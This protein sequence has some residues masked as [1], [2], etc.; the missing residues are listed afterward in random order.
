[1][2][3]VAAD[4]LTAACYSAIQDRDC[5][6]GGVTGTAEDTIFWRKQCIRVADICSEFGHAAVDSKHCM[7]EGGEIVP[8]RKIV[9]RV[10][11]SEEFY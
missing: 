8:V 2:L 1:M 6:E 3:R 11:A 7:K 4:P 10:L 9:K 5:R